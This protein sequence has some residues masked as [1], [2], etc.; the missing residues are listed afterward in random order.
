MRTEVIVVSIWLVVS[1]SGE[2]EVGATTGAEVVP[3]WAEP[4]EGVTSTV[5]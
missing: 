5:V 2:T 3:V 4:S 1:C